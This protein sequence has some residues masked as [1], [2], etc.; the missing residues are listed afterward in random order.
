MRIKGHHKNIENH[1]PLRF[2]YKTLIKIN[3]FI[4]FMVSNL[5][6]KR[7]IKIK[8]MFEK[9]FELFFLLDLSAF[10]ID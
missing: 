2:L 10:Y 4:I 7:K 8:I 1:C 3:L 6:Q 5:N 9:N